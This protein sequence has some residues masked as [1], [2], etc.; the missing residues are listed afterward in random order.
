LPDSQLVVLDAG[1]FVW[2]EAADEYASIFA[3]RVT[4]TTAQPARNLR[5]PR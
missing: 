4:G 1:H 3:G 5:R 2:E